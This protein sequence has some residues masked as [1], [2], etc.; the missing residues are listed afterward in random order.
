VSWCRSPLPWFGERCLDRVTEIVT[1]VEM[2]ERSQLN[3]GIMAP[4]LALA[5]ADERL[6]LV[7]DIMAWVAM[8]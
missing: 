3:P 4:G 1:Y 8:R 2:T 7:S 6:P 5:I